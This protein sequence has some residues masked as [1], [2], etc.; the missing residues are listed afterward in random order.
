LVAIAAG[1]SEPVTGQMFEDV[2]PGSAFYEY[3]GRLASREFISGYPCGGAGEPCGPGNRPYF[4]PG[5]NVTRGQAAKIVSNAAGFYDPYY[6][7]QYEDVPTD[8]PFHIYIARLTIH[9]V[10]GGYPCGN[11]EPC[12]PPNDFPYFRPGN[13]V[14]RGQAAKIVSNAFFPGC[15]PT[16]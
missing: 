13:S 2:P 11:P 6:V 16:P 5:N 1:F 3:V 8:H 14:T 12:V 10:L 15:Q 7:Q 9:W 4:R